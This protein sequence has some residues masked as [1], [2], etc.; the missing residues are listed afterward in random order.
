MSI[1][2]GK[3]YRGIASQARVTFQDSSDDVRSFNT[4]RQMLK[5]NRSATPHIHKV[6]KGV[7]VLI[8]ALWEAYCE[9]LALEAATTITENAASWEQLP[10]ALKKRIAKDIR[11]DKNDLGPWKL[12]GDAWRI[13][14]LERLPGIARATL[15]NSP[16]PTQID[17]LF[18]Q[19]IGLPNLSA[20]WTAGPDGVDPRERLLECMGVR[21]AIA[22]GDTPATLITPKMI[23]DFYQTVMRLV[24]ET[25]EAVRGFIATTIG[26]SPWDA[27]PPVVEAVPTYVPGRRSRRKPPP[28][29]TLEGSLAIGPSTAETETV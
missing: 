15:F 2:K 24:E 8:A 9:D 10:L 5:G 1:P 21:G 28:T 6:A 26:S 11:D 12:A 7:Y 3:L 13:H 22:H 19:A 16:K 4:L 20:S 27:P 29:D 17:E 14:C 18:L 25:D 23:S